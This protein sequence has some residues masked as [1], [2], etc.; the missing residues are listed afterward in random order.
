MGHIRNMQIALAAAGFYDRN[1]EYNKNNL[2][3]TANE[4]K[5]RQ[6]APAGDENILIVEV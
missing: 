4:G 3:P 1:I 5:S 2:H 6:E